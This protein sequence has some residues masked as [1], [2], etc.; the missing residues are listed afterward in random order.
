MNQEN[1]AQW[2]CQGLTVIKDLEGLRVNE[3][4]LVCPVRVGHEENQVD[5]DLLELP[6][7][8]ENPVDQENQDLKDLRA[9]LDNVEVLENKVLLEEAVPLD[10]VDQGVNQVTYFI[11]FAQSDISFICFLFSESV[12]QIRLRV[13]RL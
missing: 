8:E 4:R 2:V 5:K 6:D 3:D 10:H 7:P 11:G 9:Q 13:M 12:L 1:R